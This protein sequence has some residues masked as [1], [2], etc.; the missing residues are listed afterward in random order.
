MNLQFDEAVRDHYTHDWRVS[1]SLFNRLQTLL[2]SWRPKSI[3]ETGPGLSSIL[4]Y[5]Y[6]RHWPG[7]RYFSL[8]HAGPFHDRFVDHAQSLGFDTGNAFA[9]PLADDEYY[10]GCPVP[11]ERYDL[12]LLDGPASSESRALP[13]TLEM[14]RDWVHPDSI[15]IQDDTHRAPERSAVDVIVSWFPAGHF[16]REELQDPNFPRLSTLL[17]PRASGWSRLKRRFRSWRPGR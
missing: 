10:A 13:R 7:I 11:K 15:V 6:A 14:I 1:D 16:C 2:A 4:F 17:T 12:I 5:R 9:V 3:V 8:N